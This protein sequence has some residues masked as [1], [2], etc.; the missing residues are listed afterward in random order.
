MSDWSRYGPFRRVEGSEQEHVEDA[1]HEGNVDLAHLK[2]LH[3][4]AHV[5]SR[6]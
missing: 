1:C 6:P 2:A 5:I 4:E 3:D